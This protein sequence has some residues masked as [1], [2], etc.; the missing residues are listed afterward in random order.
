MRNRIVYMNPAGGFLRGLFFIAP[1]K[2]AFLEK[3]FLF[4]QKIQL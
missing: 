4:L 3:V 2:L 1:Q